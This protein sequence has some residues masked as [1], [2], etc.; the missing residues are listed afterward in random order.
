MPDNP[1]RTNAR[2]WRRTSRVLT[3][4]FAIIGLVTVLAMSTP[5]VLWWA[6]AYSG[7]IEQP[8]GDVLI[9]LSAANDDQGFISYSS[10]WR[11][12][13]A[14]L[15]WQ[16]GAFHKI[17][18]S[19]GRGPGILNFLVA[20]GVPRQ[21]ITAEWQSKSTRENA[22]NTA[23]LI[24]GIPGTKVLLTSDFHMYRAIRVFRK[25][26]IDVTPMPVPDVLKLGQHWNS[27]FQA[28]ETM[29]IESAKI[30]DYRLHGWI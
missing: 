11:A 14:L 23:R 21:A 8:R 2:S 18:V 7:P 20:E 30:V 19:G 10:Y 9:V 29:V 12:R 16:T 13:Y 24:Q 15:A 5:I 22:I 26:G 6:H 4:I 27:R 17:V 28:F 25:V 3:R 1:V